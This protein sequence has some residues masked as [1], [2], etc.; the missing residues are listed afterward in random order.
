MK[1]ATQ[2]N[3]GNA[4]IK[5]YSGTGGTLPFEFS[6]IYVLFFSAYGGFVSST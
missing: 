3:P 4:S 2:P 5:V 6:S 1:P